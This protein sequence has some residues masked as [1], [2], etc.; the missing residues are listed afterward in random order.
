MELERRELVRGGRFLS[1]AEAKC[2]EEALLRR[3]DSATTEPEGCASI[4][5]KQRA[6]RLV[7]TK[8]TKMIFGAG[9]PPQTP[10][11]TESTLITLHLG[12]LTTKAH[13]TTSI[14]SHLGSGVKPQLKNPLCVLC[15]L[16]ASALNQ[17]FPDGVEE[18]PSRSK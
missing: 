10:K 16:C 7:A 15:A 13:G 8:N 14:S 2:A 9:V 18:F 4:R 3:A 1:H 12:G 11:D 17:F 5:E 6:Q